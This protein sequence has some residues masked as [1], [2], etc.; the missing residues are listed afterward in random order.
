MAF[1]AFASLGLS[2]VTRFTSPDLCSIA[3]DNMT[4]DRALFTERAK[5]AC[6]WPF[7]ES[8]R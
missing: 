8:A 7:G 5:S 6:G 1:S 2:G 4:V 3:T